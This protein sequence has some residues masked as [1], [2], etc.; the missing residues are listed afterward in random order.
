[1]N[2][3]IR[4]RNLRSIEWYQK[5]ICANLVR[6]YQY[7]TRTNVVLVITNAEFYIDFKNINH[8]K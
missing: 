6:L 4:F 2:G 3:S 7:E 5:N 1:M 8:L